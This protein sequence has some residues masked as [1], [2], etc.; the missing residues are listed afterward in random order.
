MDEVFCNLPQLSVSLPEIDSLRIISN[1][2]IKYVIPLGIQCFSAYFLKENNLKLT[3][4]PFDWILS[5][6]N[7]ILDM[8]N[9]NFEKFL[10][11]DYYIY[12]NINDEKN[13]H[14]LYLPDLY[15]FNHKNPIKYENHLYFQRC[16]QRF[17]NV[18]NKPE[19]K[20]FIMTILSNEIKNELDN[21]HKLKK[22][23][24]SIIINYDIIC[25]FQ[26]KTGYQ[27]KEI[28]TYDNL[29]IIQITTISDSDGFIFINNEDHEFYKNIIYSFYNFDLKPIDF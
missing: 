18:I 28:Y 24:D 21:I 12:K 1:E 9:D 10:N 23:L 16:I 17:Y 7:I 22:K 27:S 8:L 11:K 5:N 13:K 15:M 14:S 4:Y 25:I 20:L 19:K 3:S 26:K 29:K 2:N 6:P